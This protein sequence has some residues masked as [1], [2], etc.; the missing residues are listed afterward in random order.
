LKVCLLWAE[1]SPIQDDKM[2][3]SRESTPPPTK[4]P[5]E[6]S[7]T[8]SES[9]DVAPKQRAL[10][11]SPSPIHN[12]RDLGQPSSANPSKDVS[13]A[14]PSRSRSRT[15]APASD[16]DSSPIRPN[17]KPKNHEES[18]EVDSEEERRRRAAAI[19]SGATAKRGTRQPLKRGGKRF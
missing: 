6:D 4:S 13:P 18:D 19:K 14:L 12:L 5:Q 16:S 1:R 2:V 15:K 8:E 11:A 17:K 10:L 3:P 9:E 7:A